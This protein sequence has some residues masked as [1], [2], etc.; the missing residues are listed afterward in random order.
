MATKSFSAEV[1]AWVK[2]TKERIE[3]V[4]KTAAQSVFEEVVTGPAM[5][6]D[7]G[8]LRASFTATL[9]QPLAI[10]PKKV[11]PK[12]AGKNSFPAQDY[13]LAINGA[14][15]GDVIYGTFTAAYARPREHRDG[16]VRLAAQNW[17]QHVDR[18]A[19]TIRGKVGG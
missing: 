18:A 8:F 6:V 5:R 11:P 9:N 16:F 7:T 4:R 14:K 10:D 1:D 12:G 17:Q 15:L 13:T 2:E 3:A 19:R